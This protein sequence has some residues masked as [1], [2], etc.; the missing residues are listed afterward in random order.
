MIVGFCTAKAREQ[1]GPD[2][3]LKHVSFA[4]P[5][6]GCASVYEEK[7]GAPVYFEM[8]FTEIVF[9][10]ELLDLPMAGADPHLNA[11][12]TEHADA[13]LATILPSPPR[14][15]FVAELEHLI[16]TGLDAGDFTLVR[17]ADQVGMSART[18]QRKLRDAGLTHR[19]LVRKVRQEVAARSLQ[20]PVSQGRIARALGYS[21]P[22]AFQRAFKSWSGLTPAQVRTR[23]A[24]RRRA[25]RN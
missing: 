3:R 20:A 23:R 19:G 2:W 16:R 22:G 1:F 8:P 11:V 10:R 14:R 13:L 4:H 18:V 24:S 21:S 9:S 17:L 6:H 12:L 7:C 15:P 5:A 25:L